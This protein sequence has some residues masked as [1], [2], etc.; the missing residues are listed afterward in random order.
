MQPVL[1]FFLF[2][3]RA[4]TDRTAAAER[5]YIIPHPAIAGGSTTRSNKWAQHPY[6]HF[7]VL[8]IEAAEQSLKQVAAKGFL[9]V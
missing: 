8:H 4:F 6:Q 7:L 2:A 5:H 1:S 3:I 9:S